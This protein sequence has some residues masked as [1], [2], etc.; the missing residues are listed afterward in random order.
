MYADASINLFR[1]ANL[2]VFALVF[3]YIYKRYLKGRIEEKINQKEAIVKGLLEQGHFLQAR[4]NDLDVHY[5]IQEKK[6]QGI[7]EKVDEWNQSFFLDQ[8]NKEQEKKMYEQQMLARAC[9]KN[10]IYTQKKLHEKILPKIIA[11]AHAQLMA[12]FSNLH[13]NKQFTNAVIERL[14]K[15]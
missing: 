8:A 10:Q 9:V 3:G 4:S 11:D 15:L 7:K 6:A 2:I 1:V 14:E 12:E 13:T 5:E